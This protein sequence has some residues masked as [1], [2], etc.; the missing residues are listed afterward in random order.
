MRRFLLGAFAF[1]LLSVSPSHA[2]QSPH[3][4]GIRQL[5][6]KQRQQEALW[7]VPRPRLDVALDRPLPIYFDT[8]AA[9]A[10]RG[11]GIR[12]VAV[13][14]I[15]IVIA[16]LSRSL[17]QKIWDRVTERRAVVAVRSDP[18][19][20]LDNTV[21]EPTIDLSETTAPKLTDPMK[22]EKDTAE[23]PAALEVEKTAVPAIVLPKEEVEPPAVVRNPVPMPFDE[24]Q[25]GWG[26]ATIRSKERFGRSGFVELDFELPDP[27][28]FVPLDL[29]EPMTVCCL[30]PDDEPVQADFFPLPGDYGK[31]SLLVNSKPSLAGTVTNVESW[32]D[33]QQDEV[34]QVVVHDLEIGDQVAIR[35]SGSSRLEY[36]GEYLPLTSIVYWAVGTGI[37]PVLDQLRT[38]L[39]NHEF[40][41]DQ[42]SVLWVNR[43]ADDFDI[44]ENDLEDVYESSPELLNV[45]LVVDEHMEFGGDDI[46][47]AVSTFYPGMMAVVAGPAENTKSAVDFLQ[48]TKNFPADCI[49]VL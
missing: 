45:A 11:G 17:I 42:A 9:A 3:A 43:Q 10:T 29:G 40:S 4:L 22:D 7:S 39:N 24:A 19:M 36:Q 20:L 21:A 41:I 6:E 44:L 12:R 31:V 34:A 32:A 16:T 26:V 48:S 49:C 30:D 37:V 23:L 33:R 47:D 46:A 8:A 15:A 2:F 14:V 5:K 38:V 1:L 18:P 27:S 28:Y 13:I 35:P 25:E